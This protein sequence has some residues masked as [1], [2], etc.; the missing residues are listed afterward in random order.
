MVYNPQCVVFDPY[1]RNVWSSSSPQLE[2][3]SL[4]S[5][6]AAQKMLALGSRTIRR[7]EK[8]EMNADPNSAYKP[9][10]FY[11]SLIRSPCT[12]LTCHAFLP[13]GTQED[14]EVYSDVLPTKWCHQHSLA[15]CN[16][17][18]NITYTS[19]IWSFVELQRCQYKQSFNYPV[20][21]HNLKKPVEPVN[22]EELD[23]QLRHLYSNRGRLHLLCSSAY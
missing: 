8:D 17:P 5:Y 1:R 10:S 23:L 11:G 15:T 20:F 16:L 3:I 2:S 19:G 4:D 6:V 18:Q 14:K 9:W 12:R 13:I 22:F 21:F 7:K